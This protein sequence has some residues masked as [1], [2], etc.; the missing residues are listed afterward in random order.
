METSKTRTGWKID[1]MEEEERKGAEKYYKELEKE[2]RNL[3]EE[4]CTM[5]DIEDE[6]KWLEETLTKVLDKF[7]PV[8]RVCSQSKPWW[9]E[10]IREARKVAGR[11]RRQQGRG[12]TIEEEAKKR[13]KELYR[14]IRRS[15]RRMWNGWLQKADD[16]EVEDDKLHEGTDREPASQLYGMKTTT[17]PQLS[18]KEN[19]C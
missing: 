9:N 16:K 10:H 14:T 19:P 13:D 8:S 2:R 3:D 12:I 4:E 18:R 1:N 5:E 17:S 15:K 11:V 6:A 7:M